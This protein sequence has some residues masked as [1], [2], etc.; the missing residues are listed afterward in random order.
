[1]TT[2]PPANIRYSRQQNLPAVGAAGQQRLADAHLLIMGA[3][4]LGTPAS[5]YLA[6]SGI[7]HISICDFD[8]VDATNL[9]RQ[10]LY[11]DADVDKPKAIVA[12]ERLREINPDLKCAA[13]AERLNDEQLASAIE[14]ADVVLDCTDNFASRWTINAACARHST[15]LVSGAAI[16]LEGQLSVFRHDLKRGPCFRCLYEDADENLN[17]CAG[18]GIL[19]PVAGT[20]GCMMATEALKLILNVDSDLAGQLWTY[21]AASGQSRLIKIPPRPDCPVCGTN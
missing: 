6:S 14:Q 1:M 4:G 5:L 11:R 13:L 20:I 10:I 16:R 8:S 17:D 12:A 7:G 19:A 3:G 9:P 2:K 15:A 18:Q 21:D